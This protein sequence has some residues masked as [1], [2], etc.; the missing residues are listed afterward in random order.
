MFCQC[1][2]PYFIALK[3]RHPPA[4]ANRGWRRLA[5]E[6]LMVARNITFLS[7]F[8][9]RHIIAPLPLSQTSRTA[10]YTLPSA[11]LTV[12]IVALK[13]LPCHFFCLCNF[14]ARHDEKTVIKVF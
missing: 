2:Q 11:C 6:A 5:C 3:P 9:R 7:A 8:N 12:F 4:S 1:P 13:A 10:C 14:F